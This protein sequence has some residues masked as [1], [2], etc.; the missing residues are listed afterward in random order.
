MGKLSVT[1]E[2][3]DIHIIEMLIFV[4][5]LLEEEEKTPDSVYPCMY[6]D[7]NKLSYLSS[8]VHYNT[9]FNCAVLK[10]WRTNPK[11]WDIDALV[12]LDDIARHQGLDDFD[13][14]YKKNVRW[15]N[16]ILKSMKARI[17]A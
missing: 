3:E 17:D 10:Y 13:M 14:Y 6:M 9:A 4:N 16:R 15:I 8:I 1:F 12:A 7:L 2:T 5:K 11:K